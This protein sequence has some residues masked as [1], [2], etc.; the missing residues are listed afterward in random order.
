M[1]DGRRLGENIGVVLGAASGEPLLSALV[2]K[3]AARMR[4]TPT[5]PSAVAVI[6]WR[7]RCEV[8]KSNRVA[9]ASECAAKDAREQ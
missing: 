6:R 5:R 3:S 9:F 8:I 7:F 2:Q 4:M 1:V